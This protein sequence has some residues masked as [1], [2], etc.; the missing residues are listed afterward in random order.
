LTRSLRKPIADDTPVRVGPV[1]QRTWIKRHA[2]GNDMLI[3]DMVVYKE[4]VPTHWAGFQRPPGL[5]GVPSASVTT[6]GVYPHRPLASTAFSGPSS[7]KSFAPPGSGSST[8]SAP[9]E[10]SPFAQ[11]GSRSEPGEMAPAP[12]SPSGADTSLPQ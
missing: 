4:I 11:P 6:G 9:P 7:S 8:N 10:R 12:A 2:D 3:G 1:V 5:A